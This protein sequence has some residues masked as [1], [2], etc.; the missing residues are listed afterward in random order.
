[1]IAIDTFFCY[2]RFPVL[3]PHDLFFLDIK[4]KFK[5]QFAIII[6]Q[7]EIRVL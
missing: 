1:M 2:I 6:M 4:N 7:L 5:L 3:K